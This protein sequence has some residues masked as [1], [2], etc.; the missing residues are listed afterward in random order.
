MSFH[1][2]QSSVDQ[3]L[4]NA[5]G[6]RFVLAVIRSTHYFTGDLSYD[7]YSFTLGYSNDEYH[8]ARLYNER[9]DC[10]KCRRPA[11]RTYLTGLMYYTYG[12]VDF[13]CE[14]CFTGLFQK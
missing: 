11:S 7:T 3:Y 10:D 12:H 4:H 5:Y 8:R 13:L 6:R 9:Y 2:W 1:K 14:K